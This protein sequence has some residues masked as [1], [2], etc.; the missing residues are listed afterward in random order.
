MVK[1]RALLLSIGLLL[2]IGLISTA[3]AVW[4]QSDDKSA[5][6]L[7]VDSLQAAH[8]TAKAEDRFVQEVNA[9]V[10]QWAASLEKDP[11]WIHVVARHDRNKD[12][13]GVLTNGQPIPLDYISDTWYQIDDKKS[14]IARVTV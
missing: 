11:G 12:R 3:M 14:I 7:P 10:T 9:L 6:N 4:A 5:N 8:S 2:F 13:A 1:R